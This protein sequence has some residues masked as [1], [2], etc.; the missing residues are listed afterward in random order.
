MGGHCVGTHAS[1]VGVVHHHDVADDLKMR[2]FLNCFSPQHQVVV[3]IAC[4]MTS[5][6]P[7]P[8]TMFTP[9]DGLLEDPSAVVVYRTAVHLH[10]SSQAISAQICTPLKYQ[11]MVGIASVRTGLPS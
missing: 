7:R 8:V 9:A 10:V 3:E 11:V 5:L 2:S 1:S 6:S 4:V